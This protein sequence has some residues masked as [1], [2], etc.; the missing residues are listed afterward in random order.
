[1]IARRKFMHVRFN[2]IANGHKYG[3]GY[4]TDSCNYKANPF[5][6]QKFRMFETYGDGLVQHSSDWPV[7][8]EFAIDYL[9]S[10]AA[11]MLVDEDLA[12]TAIYQFSGRELSEEA[13]A[14]AASLVYNPEKDREWGKKRYFSVS[15]RKVTRDQEKSHDNRYK[16]LT[17][18]HNGKPAAI[19]SMLAPEYSGGL[20]RWRCADEI[21]VWCADHMKNGYMEMPAVFLKWF[22]RDR[23]GD[24]MA[25]AR[26][27]RDAF[28]ACKA[29]GEWYRLRK[30]AEASV[31]SYRKGLERQAQR[32]AAAQAE[33]LQLTAE[34]TEEA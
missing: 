11:R 4:D 27:F 17:E 31:E 21:R 20:Q 18:Y 29:A 10:L 15:L 6:T 26:E 7:T 19:Y 30:L 14:F 3:Y 8:E 22:E 25:Q 2:S 23:Q 33:Q 34:A 28:E 9:Y 13:I 32:E 5:L 16:E 1:M 12:G 24:Q